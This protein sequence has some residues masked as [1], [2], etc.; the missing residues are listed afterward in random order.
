MEKLDLTVP[1]VKP[2]TTSWTITTIQ[3]YWDAKIVH[4]RLRDSNG[5]ETV[6]EY[7]GDE[8]VTVLNDLNN[9]KDAGSLQKRVLQQLATDGF[10][11]GTISGVPD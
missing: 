4:V 1:E 3:M 8:A 5:E 9:P 11:S 7:T 10:L 2:A 6:F